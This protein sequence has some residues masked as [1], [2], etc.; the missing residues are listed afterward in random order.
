MPD[1][2]RQ[3]V[4]DLEVQRA[5]ALGKEVQGTFDSAGGARVQRKRF[6]GRKVRR[7]NQFY[8]QKY[9]TRMGWD[10]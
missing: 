1:F 6:R 9:R 2:D 10:I 4:C 3:N 7:W 8:G 5:Q